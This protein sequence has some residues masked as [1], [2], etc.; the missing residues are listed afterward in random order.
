MQLY[1]GKNENSQTSNK[2]EWIRDNAL[3]F[4]HFIIIIIIYLYFCC[5]LFVLSFLVWNF[6]WLLEELLTLL[7]FFFIMRM[8]ISLFL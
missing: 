2:F 1:V 7:C 6:L 8:E 3:H 5:F 4:F